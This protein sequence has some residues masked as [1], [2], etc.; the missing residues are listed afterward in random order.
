MIKFEIQQL[1]V[2]IT[3]FV[4]NIFDQIILQLVMCFLLSDPNPIGTNFSDAWRE[5]CITRL[6]HP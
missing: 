4:P 1:L 5:V 2:F 6:M 3:K